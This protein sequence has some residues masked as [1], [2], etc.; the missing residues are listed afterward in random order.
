[1]LQ[2]QAILARLKWES[3]LNVFELFIKDLRLLSQ[4]QEKIVPGSK[5]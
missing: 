5:F 2:H 4:P 1:M 3:V